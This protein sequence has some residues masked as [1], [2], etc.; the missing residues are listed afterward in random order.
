MMQGD[1]L[2][3]QEVARDAARALLAGEVKKDPGGDTE[4]NGHV[5]TVILTLSPDQSGPAK[6]R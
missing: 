6:P 1:P 2:F 4:D 3:Q 5:S